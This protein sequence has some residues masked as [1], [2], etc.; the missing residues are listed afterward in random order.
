MPHQ[1]TSVMVI[2][3][4]FVYLMPNSITLAGS[5]LAPN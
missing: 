1:P 4:I 3:T 5:E 2:R